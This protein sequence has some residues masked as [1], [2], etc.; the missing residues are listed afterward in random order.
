MRPAVPETP[1]QNDPNPGSIESETPAAEKEAEE[2]SK[3]QK[4]DPEVMLKSALSAAFKKYSDKLGKK[5]NQTEEESGEGS[6][7]QKVSE[8][9]SQS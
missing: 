9:D 8:A 7:I 5:N 1:V 6:N 4:K 2:T 3:R